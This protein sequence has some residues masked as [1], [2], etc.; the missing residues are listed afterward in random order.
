MIDAGDGTFE[1]R[2]N[3]GRCPACTGTLIVEKNRLDCSICSLSI[4]NVE[5]SGDKVLT[6]KT[7]DR[8]K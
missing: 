3:E 7:K 8:I 1:K 2:L 4:T 5:I 6:I